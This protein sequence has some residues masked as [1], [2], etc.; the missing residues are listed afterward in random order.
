MGK[1]KITVTEDE[2]VATYQSWWDSYKENKEAS[3]DYDADDYDD[4]NYAR[5]SAATFMRH[6]SKIKGE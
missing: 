6:L 1:S 2:L 4:I 3:V 5:D